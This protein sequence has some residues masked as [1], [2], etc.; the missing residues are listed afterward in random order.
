MK[1]KLL[2]A[3][4]ATM[5]YAFNLQAQQKLDIKAVDSF[6][7]YIEQSGRDIG[8]LSI[9]KNGTEIYHRDFGQQSIEGL[10]FNKDTRYQIGSITKLFT[11]VM[12]FQLIEKGQLKLDDKLAAYFP[13]IPGARDITLKNMLEHSSG[14]GD[15]VFNEENPEWLIQ[16]KVGEKGILAE[17]KKQGQLFKPGEK[18]EYSNSAYYLLA[19]ILEKVHKKNY[20]KILEQCIT[21]P[22][23]LGNITSVQ[24]NTDNIFKAYEYLDGRWSE[25]KDFEFINA[26]GVGDIAATTYD[27]N[28]FIVLLFQNKILKKESLE[29]MKPITPKEHFGRGL[30]LVPFYEHISYGHGG[31]TRGTHSAVAYNEKDSVSCA[32]AINGERYAHNNFAIGFLSS[33]YGKAYTFPG[34]KEISLKPEDLDK[35][36]GVYSNP[37]LPIKITISKEGSMLMAQGTGQPSFPLTAYDADKFE[38]DQ[39]GVKFEFKPASNSLI[40]HQGGMNMEMKRE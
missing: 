30:M 12:I 24:G 21:K 5:G 3:L 25:Q 38:F 28:R 19:R 29:Q 33:L 37:D 10:V 34:F 4:C 1:R 7:N 23:R 15:Y 32:F 9:C 27:L 16:R 20:G 36:A 11:A 18:V 26:L 14:L 6:V 13:D 2:L 40:F 8:S 35:Y 39:A 22:Y 17:I 31:D